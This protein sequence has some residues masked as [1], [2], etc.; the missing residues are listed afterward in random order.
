MHQVWNQEDP[1]QLLPIIPGPYHLLQHVDISVSWLIGLRYILIS[2][3]ALSG[4]DLYSAHDCSQNTRG[5]SSV[6]FIQCMVSFVHISLSWVMSESRVSVAAIK[7]SGYSE[8]G[9]WKSPTSEHLKQLGT[10]KKELRLEN[11]LFER[12]SN[13]EFQ[14]GN[15]G[16][17]LELRFSDLKITDIMI[18]PSIFLSCQ[19]Y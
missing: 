11:N 18:F 16:L 4:R 17:F 10:I 9:T 15:S 19:L 14:L 2:Y 8:L 1:E 6:Y 7:T 13:S 5:R 3:L 12:S